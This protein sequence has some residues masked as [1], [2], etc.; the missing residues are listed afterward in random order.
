MRFLQL[1]IQVVDLMLKSVQPDHSVNSMLACKALANLVAAGHPLS[2]E[3]VLKLGFEIDFLHL[4]CCHRRC[5]LCKYHVQL[6]A[7]SPQTFTE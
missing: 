2:V 6:A 5:P 7:H 4:R 1:M 3:K